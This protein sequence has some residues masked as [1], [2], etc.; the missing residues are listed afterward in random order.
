M[1]LVSYR[2]EVSVRPHCG[3]CG[4]LWDC[5]WAP[6]G[7]SLVEGRRYQDCCSHV[8]RGSPVNEGFL[9]RH[10]PSPST[11]QGE[12]QPEDKDLRQREGETET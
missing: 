4:D 11:L 1:L 8:A 3:D 12:Y 2:W 5:R 9:L 10:A 6:D 7:P